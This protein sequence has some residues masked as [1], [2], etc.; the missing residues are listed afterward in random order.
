MGVL[1]GKYIMRAQKVLRSFF[2]ATIVLENVWK[3]N[4]AKSADSLSLVADL[5]KQSRDNKF[6]LRPP[7]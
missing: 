4:S 6:P 3:G 7:I 1:C 5:Q 2:A